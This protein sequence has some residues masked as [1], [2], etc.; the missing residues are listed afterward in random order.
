M[1]S[2]ARNIIEGAVKQAARLLPEQGPIGVF[3]HQNPLVA[4][5][6]KKFED[7]VEWAAEM[8]GSEPYLTHERYL[9]EL[10]QGRIREQDLDEILALADAES[11]A[12]G[13]RFLGGRLSQTEVWRALLSIASRPF[14]DETIT[15]LLREKKEATEFQKGVEA[16][17]RRRF[18]SESGAKTPAE[19]LSALWE[20]LRSRVKFEARSQKKTDAPEAGELNGI[21]IRL[22]ASFL[23]QGVS[24][25][26]MPDRDKGFLAAFRALAEDG[27]VFLPEGLRWVPRQWNWKE[28]D[29]RD[30]FQT[31]ELCLSR[32]GVPRAEWETL[33]VR[34]LLCLPG[35]AGMMAVLE[36][37]PH[38]VSQP[39][40]ASLADFLAVRLLLKL[41]LKARLEP[42][43]ASSRVPGSL[44]RVYEA[45]RFFQQVGLSAPLIREA[46]DLNAL[47]EE[48]D[49]FS[50]VPRR[51]FLHRAFERTY[52]C[53]VLDAVAINLRRPK[54]AV[55]ADGPSVQ[56]VTCIDEREESL[57]RHLEEADPRAETFSIAGF[58]S[59][60][61]WYQGI[62]DSFPVPLCPVV[63]RPKHAISEAPRSPA[64]KDGK[65]RHHLVRTVRKT[66]HHGSRH[67]LGGLAMSVA[68]GVLAVVPLG[69]RLHSPRLSGRLKRILRET[70]LPEM[71]TGLALETAVP[72]APDAQI[73]AGFSVADM[74]ERVQAVL[75]ELGLTKKFSRLVVI[76]GHGSSSANNP[77]KSAYDCGA[78]GGRGG[79]PNARAFAAMA[80]LPAVRA[81][82]KEKGII[83]PVTTWF[84]G[85]LHDTCSDS[86]RF[87]DEASVPKTHAQA[88]Q[89]A[90]TVL[91]RARMFDAHE[92]CRRFDS[93]RHLSAPLA[94]QHVEGRCQDLREPRPECGHASNASLIIAP[95]RL[96]RGLFLDRRAFLTSYDNAQDPTGD[97]LL[98]SL[99]AVVPVCAGISLEYYF[100][101]VDN[102]EYG[103]GTKLPHNIS[104]L[105]G[106]TN[107]AFSDLRAGLP[108]QMVEIHEPMRLLTLVETDLFKMEKVLAA[109]AGIRRAVENDWI[110]LVLV[111]PTTGALA[112]FYRGKFQPYHPEDPALLEVSASPAY[113]VGKRDNL[114][115]VLVTGVAI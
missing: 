50:D 40:R 25:W 101:Y 78:C 89:H 68:G 92:R 63:V 114:R 6:D 107:G 35:W 49:A 96:T 72:A 42:S 67:P 95:R 47:L 12:P 18:L 66:V 43:A 100:S 32:L 24:R 44:H 56:L 46:G 85:G 115:P 106:V 80:N 65:G 86:V 83:I 30:A 102:E 2:E 16:P 71:E 109:H 87:F 45:F 5:E 9:K 39:V 20:V 54:T 51:R 58:F 3:I 55:S 84:I 64:Q 103:S 111:D 33:I 15:W 28:L 112:R 13:R 10:G 94:L 26:A 74:A 108:L 34:E 99:S 60:D 4:F 11:A 73:Q 77:H 21:L 110:Q 75:G 52:R 76:L 93:A 27:E 90:T 104:G 41:S 19:A 7:M 1:D 48:I 113:Y 97:I 105:I 38:L 59:V 36:H 79:G 23:D 29:G 31:C 22:A 61:M 8:R 37:R 82:I 69:L 57:R 62:Y 14:A 88:F 98:R 81:L 70:F 17:A 91:N 53:R